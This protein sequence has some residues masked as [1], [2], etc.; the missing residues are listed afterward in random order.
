MG[1]L[2]D[3]WDASWEER[4]WKGIPHNWRKDV[5][6]EMLTKNS[7]FYTNLS[8]DQRKWLNMELLKK[9]KD[10]KSWNL[11]ESAFVQEIEK[12]S[13][14]TLPRH[15]TFQ[16]SE[17]RHILDILLKVLSIHN[18]QIGYVHGM[19]LW[20][21]LLL[22]LYSDDCVFFLVQ[23]LFY[24]SPNRQDVESSSFY[25][26]NRLYLK[27][28][29]FFDCAIYTHSRLL[30]LWYPKIEDRLNK[31]GISP[32]MYLKKWLFSLFVGC[33]AVSCPL[34]TFKN[35]NGGILSWP[36]ILRIW[37]LYLY[38]GWDIL[39][40]VSVAI[41]KYY[42]NQILRMDPATLMVFLGIEDGNTETNGVVTDSLPCISN[43]DHFIDLVQ[44]LYNVGK[45]NR[46]SFLAE[47]NSSRKSIDSL[48]SLS[49]DTK[50]LQA[51]SG[52]VLVNFFKN[53][54]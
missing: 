41:L 3:G 32:N 21:G 34:S 9:F 1:G 26:L 19:N 43:P 13:T 8:K 47:Y 10:I 23:K 12:D 51:R 46:L 45:R 30:N 49:S 42:S 38:H 40:V 18:F 37:D 16:G 44:S 48:S 4:L 35:S 7:G 2:D 20:V 28:G 36:T 22:C 53:S 17:G 24:D 5:W 11:S 15:V 50:A 33:S 27:D 14:V 6:N 52:K 25:G 31:F 39:M 29:S 54:F